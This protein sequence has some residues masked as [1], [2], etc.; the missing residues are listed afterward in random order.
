L[1][2]ECVVDSVGT[3]FKTADLFDTDGRMGRT[4]GTLVVERHDTR[5]A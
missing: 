1:R 2:S 5:S 4:M 3:G